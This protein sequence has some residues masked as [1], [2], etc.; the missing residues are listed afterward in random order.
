[1]SEHEKE[2]SALTEREVSRREFLK[3]A[4]V[5]GASVGVLGALGGLVAAC[6]GTAE[7]TTTA[8]APASTT[9][10][11][12]A[13]GSSST[14][15]AAP[16]SSS[17]TAASAG[18][19]TGR[20]IK[21]GLVYPKT[22]PLS[23]FAKPDEW[24]VS[25]FKKDV[26]NG[27]L[28]GDGKLHTFDVILQDS[29]SQQSRASQVAGDL[30]LN[31]KVDML[32]ASSSPDN[33]NPV[34]DQAESNGLPMLA[35]F[36]PWQPFYNRGGKPPANPYTWTWMYHFGL[37]DAAQVRMA[38]WAQ[39]ETNKKVGLLFPN[40]ADGSAWANDKTGF[41]PKVVAAGYAVTQP[42]LHDSTAEDFTQ[43][44]SE[45]KKNAC[46]I[47]SGIETPPLFT[48][49]W[50]QAVQQGYNPKICTMGK[51]LLFHETLIALGDSG[52]G[53][54]DEVVWHP[55]FPYKSSLSGLTAQQYADL[56]TS[57]TGN[58]W[59]EPLGQYGKYEWAVDIFKRMTDIEDKSQFPKV[60]AATKLDTIQGLVDFTLPV[61]P[62]S[63]H[64]VPNVFKIRI[65][66]G[67]WVKT[68]DGGKWPYDLVLCAANGSEIPTPAKM[69][70][71][72]YA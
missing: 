55:S 42:G 21:L 64:P 4:G 50:K 19:E 10:T 8:A 52:I 68:T 39:L 63:A 11:A 67:Q 16:A 43:Q 12:A 5:S 9:T 38:L 45:F 56:Y 57:E 53:L 33:A 65:A 37:E 2:T 23:S 29:Q 40:D 26:A 69:Q 48:N 70:P 1:M 6:G 34:A 22:G 47:C 58:G 28:C 24:I 35:S 62:K 51:A 30:I 44:I 32:L 66:A 18:T 27:V 72:T 41:T 59:T 54:S 60:V 3:V 36:V 46:E 15:A 17:T 25:T 61:D 20:A 14:T 13:A 31:T 71:I 49:F 7:T